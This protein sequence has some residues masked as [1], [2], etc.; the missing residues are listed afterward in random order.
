MGM[1]MQG[2]SSTRLWQFEIGGKGDLD[3]IT[4]AV[5]VDDDRV[6]RLLGNDAGKQGNHACLPICFMVA[7]WA[8]QMATARASEASAWAISGRL[9][10]AF[11][12]CCTC[13]L[14]ARP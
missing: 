1:D 4:D 12:I 5:D 9:S 7:E 8:W 14:A 6:W 3:P 11:T 13:S 10:S 2:T